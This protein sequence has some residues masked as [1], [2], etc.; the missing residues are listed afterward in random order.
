MIG[1]T[2]TS[3]RRIFSWLSAPLAA[4]LILWALAPAETA[5]PEPMPP[6][7]DSRQEF[8]VFLK[9]YCIRC[10]GPEKQ[11]GKIAAL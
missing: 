8:S 10:H 1:T 9:Q 5:P 3:A 4:V 6:A 2:P 11:R 7:A